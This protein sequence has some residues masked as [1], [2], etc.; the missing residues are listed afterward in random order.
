MAV[1]DSAGSIA[2]SYELVFIDKGKS[3]GLERGNQLR[4]MARTDHVTGDLGDRLER[5]IGLLQV[6]DVRSSAST[7]LILSSRMVIE[8]GAIARTIVS[9]VPPRKPPKKEVEDKP[10]AKEET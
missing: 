8:P 9:K 2:G 7:C 10:A 5:P 3:Q 4:V 1:R 6:V